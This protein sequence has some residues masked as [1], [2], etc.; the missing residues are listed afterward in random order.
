MHQ[1]THCLTLPKPFSQIFYLEFIHQ[2]Y[3][4]LT[5]ISTRPASGL[6]T[7]PRQTSLHKPIHQRHSSTDTTP[8]Q[9]P[10]THATTHRHIRC[11]PPTDVVD[12]QTLMPSQHRCRRRVRNRTDQAD[13]I[14]PRTRNRT[15]QAPDRPS[16]GSDW[17]K[18]G[19]RQAAYRIR[20][21]QTK[22]DRT[23]SD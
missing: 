4:A 1:Q 7:S 13:R 14:R 12:A 10:Q 18:S 21:D 16:T 15:S 2:P 9:P 17:T 8:I 22:P 5:L 3:T 19:I 6:H 20:P 23:G 11:R